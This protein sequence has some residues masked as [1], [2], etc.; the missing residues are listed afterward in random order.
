M[1]DEAK[2]FAQQYELMN[3]LTELRVQLRDYRSEMNADNAQLR[4]DMNAAHEKM[5]RSIDSL[6]HTAAMGRG[7]IQMLLWI[8]AIV[9]ALGGFVYMAVSYFRPH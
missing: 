2:S 6:N 5:W 3:A 4:T 9:G 7:A 8:G 1:T